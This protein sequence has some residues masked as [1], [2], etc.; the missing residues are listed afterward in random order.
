MRIARETPDLLVVSET[1]AGLR[2]C[3]A[4]LGV[5]GAAL[6]SIGSRESSTPAVI[7]GACILSVGAMFAL[8]PATSTF[9]FNRSEKRLTV[10]RRHFWTRGSSGTE[11][12]P[13]RDVVAVRAEKGTFATEGESTWRIIVQLASGRTIPFESYYTSGYAAKVEMAARIA[14]F[15]GVATSS[16]PRGQNGTSLSEIA[17][18]AW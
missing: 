12:F 6:V 17:P 16:H 10:S 8:L 5:T 14:A 18:G 9:V 1:A 7:A 13:L 4:V 15:V 11:E 3:G 2:V